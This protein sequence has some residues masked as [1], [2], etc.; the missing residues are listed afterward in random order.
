MS[1]LTN[2]AAY[3]KGLADGM[4]MDKDSNEGKLLN[5][6]IA[7]LGDI[8]AEIEMLDDEQ[9]FIADKLDDIDDSIDILCE[10]IFEDEIYDEDEE[11]EFTI[12]CEKCGKDIFL[13]YEDF[14]CDD[15]ACPYCGEPIEIDFVCDGDCDCCE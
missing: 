4:K 10:E 7:L 3:L 2:R 8:T 1:D 11:D 5:E 15:L 14:E 12:T 6:I 13:S 9:G